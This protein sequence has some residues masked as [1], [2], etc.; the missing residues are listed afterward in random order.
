[1]GRRALAI[2]DQNRVRVA[3]K[4]KIARTLGE[5]T[6]V[7]VRHASEGPRVQRDAK[8]SAAA[9]VLLRHYET[10]AE[11]IFVWDDQ[12]DDGTTEMLKAHPLV[13]LLPLKHHGPTTCTT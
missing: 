2:R 8:R 5:Y 9:P 12:S 6:E 10:V 3:L 7:K 1:V 13:T 4:N 11:R